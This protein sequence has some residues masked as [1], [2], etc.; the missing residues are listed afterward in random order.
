MVIVAAIVVIAVVV[1]LDV[2][3]VLVAVVIVILLAVD[4]VLLEVIMF[5]NIVVIALVI[6]L[7]VVFLIYDDK[8]F[9]SSDPITQLVSVFARSPS[10]ASPIKIEK[11]E[12]STS[13]NTSATGLCALSISSL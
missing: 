5:G 4:I 9:L 6:R 2:V 13:R 12:I 3:V 8:F 10:A 1:V 7:V 11:I